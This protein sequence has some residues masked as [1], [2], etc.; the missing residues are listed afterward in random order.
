MAPPDT[1]LLAE[2]DAAR[3]RANGALHEGSRAALGQFMT[4]GVLASF[5]ASMFRDLGPEVR[6]LD[7]GAGVGSL[8]AAFLHEVA[9]RKSRPR[10]VHATVDRKSV[11]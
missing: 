5:M 6:L 2:A 7:A 4:P 1:T 3:S 10:V 11:V 8:T 9:G